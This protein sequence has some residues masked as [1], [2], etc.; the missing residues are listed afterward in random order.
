MS[1]DRPPSLVPAGLLLGAGLGGFADGIVLHQIL[2]WHHLISARESPRTVAG[3][4]A[5]TVAD[6][7]FHAGTWL[8]VVAGVAMLWRW[9]RHPDRRPAGWPWRALVGLVLAGWGAFN[10]IEGVVDHHLL[11]LHH[12]RPGPHQ[13]AYDIGFLLLG[14]ALLAGGWA[15]HR[16]AGRAPVRHPRS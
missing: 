3:L 10:L 13:A 5:N 1:V 12:V 15:L 9:A 7:V 2:R 14:A 8:L 11:E 16:G 6:G 4:E